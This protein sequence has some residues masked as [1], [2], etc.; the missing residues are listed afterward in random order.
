MFHKKMTSLC[1]ISKE[2]FISTGLDY[3]LSF[4]LY[5]IGNAVLY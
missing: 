1:I 3:V 4:A 2:I 5:G